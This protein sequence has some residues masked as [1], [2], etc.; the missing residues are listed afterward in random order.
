MTLN[1]LICPDLGR[2]RAWLDHEDGTARFAAHLDACPACQSLVAELRR[3]AET[4]GAAVASLPRAQVTD[5]DRHRVRAQLNWRRRSPRAAQPAP[6]RRLWSARIAAGGV[7]AAMLVSIV[8]ALTPEG[9]TAAAA[10]LAQFRS[11]QVVAVEVSPQS[12]ADISRTMDTLSHLG[13]VQGLRGGRGPNS[14]QGTGTVTVAEASRQVGFAVQTPD[15]ATLPAGIDRTPR[16]QVVPANELRFTFDKAKAQRYLQA[17]GQTQ[18]NLPDKFNGASLVVSTPAAAI[19][20]YSSQNAHETLVIGQ[21]GEIVVDVQGQV[22]LDEMRDFLL[23]L[24]G[25]PNE[26]VQQLK[27]IRN[28][29]ETLPIPVRTDKIHWQAATFKGSQGL[30]LN[31]N[32]GVG[33]A[34]V[35]QSGGQLYGLAGSLKAND[36]KR[37]ADSL[38]VR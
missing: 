35:W 26:T 30:L 24:P 2:W 14:A 29:R 10:F 20:E 34:A 4:A 5:A 3:D 16:V 25:L 32:S 15:P 37:V 38:A 17:N 23:S 12:Q 7:A 33:S 36:L 18:V 6:P 11:R 27:L 28:W 8:V 1:T 22:T 19:L 31:D 21:A 9:R 13:T